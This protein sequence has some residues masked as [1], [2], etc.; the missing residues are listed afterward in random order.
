MSVL[1]AE[2]DQTAFII[3][4]SPPKGPSNLSEI[5]SRGQE[6]IQ[7]SSFEQKKMEKIIFFATQ[8]SLYN[9]P[10]ARIK[11]ICK[12]SQSNVVSQANSS[13]TSLVFQGYCLKIKLF[14]IPQC[15]HSAFRCITIVSTGC[16]WTNLPI[17]FTNVEL[18]HSTKGLLRQYWDGRLALKRIWAILT[19]SN[20]PYQSQRSD[21]DANWPSG[22]C[23]EMLTEIR[24]LQNS[25]HNMLSS[26][27][28]DGLRGPYTTRLLVWKGF[29]S[30]STKTTESKAELS[31]YVVQL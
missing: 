8:S 13:K 14:S 7:Q 23:E 1:V 28:N 4:K 19:H 17:S 29:K 20:E 21:W 2:K 31:T 12:F 22:W 6:T 10:S 3:W 24:T 26:M 15:F 11:K 18:P 27:L 30:N 25:S 16:T 9:Q 5:S